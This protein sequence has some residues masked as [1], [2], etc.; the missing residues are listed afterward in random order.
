MYSSKDGL[1][2]DFHMVH[3]GSFAIGGAGLVFLEATGVEL[4]GRLSPYC[5]SIHDDSQ[6]PSIKRI[7]D[8]AHATGSVLGIQLAH[9]GRKGSVPAMFSGRYPTLVNTEDSWE[10]IGP[11]PIAYDDGWAI[12]HEM[13]K[14]DIDKTIQSYVQAT[15]RAE[16][17][18]IQVVEI[19]AA[20]GY[21]LTNFLSPITNKRTDE[22]GGSFENRIRLLL[23][24]VQA[25][26]VVWN[27]PLFVRVS[28]TEYMEGGWNVKD[29]MDLAKKLE[30]L[31]VDVLDLSSGGNNPKAE[32]DPFTG[33]Q[34]PYAEEAKKTSGI[35]T[36]AVG[37]ITTGKQAEEIVAQGKADFVAIGRQ[38]LRDPN[39][40]I[41][42]ARELGFDSTR[43]IQYGYVTKARK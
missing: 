28:A 23:E 20:H 17:A 43:I 7:A 24:I 22:Y 33:Y 10:P 16:K 37:L 31:G 25:V 4:E 5:A 34:V 32:V 8:F 38:F 15:I 1:F 9:S 35:K 36:M 6:I 14:E 29:T 26:R 42:A 12:P 18:S 40:P 39:F 13:T 30:E 2:S 19:H 41:N 21:L 27:K 11:S 3:Y